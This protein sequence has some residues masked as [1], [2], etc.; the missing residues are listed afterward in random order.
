LP[1]R[2][3]FPTLPPSAVEFLLISAPLPCREPYNNVGTRGGARPRG[4]SERPPPRRK[5]LC[6]ANFLA[7][8]TG[9]QGITPALCPPCAAPAA[10]RARR[11]TGTG[12]TNGR[13]CPG[14]GLFLISGGPRADLHTSRGEDKPAFGDRGPRPSDPVRRDA[15]LSPGQARPAACPAAPTPGRRAA[16]VS[17]PP[18]TAFPRLLPTREA[19]Q[20][21]RETPRPATH[22]RLPRPVVSPDPTREPPAAAAGRGGD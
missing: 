18:G 2:T 7:T 4:M 17:D 21:G 15:C 19:R 8:R 12:R 5:V 9:A 22:R 14:C 1:L 13:T 16:A 20:D 6:P 3:A 11:G 10:I